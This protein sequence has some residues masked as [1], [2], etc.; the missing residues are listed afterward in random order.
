M[1]C[2]S[3]YVG[4]SI[5]A[6]STHRSRGHSEPCVTASSI[7]GTVGVADEGFSQEWHKAGG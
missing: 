3:T 6:A 7:L 5:P 4:W 2:C 1:E